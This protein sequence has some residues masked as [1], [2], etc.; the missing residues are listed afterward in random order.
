MIMCK[1]IFC[2][3]IFLLINDCSADIEMVR[4]SVARYSHAVI[5]IIQ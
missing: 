4:R 5:L 3:I 1:R 2:I